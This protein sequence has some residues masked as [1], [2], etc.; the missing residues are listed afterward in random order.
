M[1]AQILTMGGREQ[2]STERVQQLIKSEKSRFFLI[3]K[4]NLKYIRT[5]LQ[6]NVTEQS[7]RANKQLC[8]SRSLG[9]DSGNTRRDDGNRMTV[10][11]HRRLLF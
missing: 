8:T 1:V 6:T 4:K 7:G 10:P 2:R 11:N 3:L 5:V 9:N